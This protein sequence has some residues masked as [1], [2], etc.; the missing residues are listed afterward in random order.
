MLGYRSADQNGG[1]LRAGGD[2]RLL[3]A[4]PDS[5]PGAARI[6]EYARRVWCLRGLG[7]GAYRLVLPRV[8]DGALLAPGI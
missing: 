7:V 1:Y 6:A 2:Q 5:K 8:K 3:R 4:V